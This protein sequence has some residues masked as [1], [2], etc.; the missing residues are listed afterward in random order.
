MPQRKAFTLVELLVVIAILALLLS[1]LV[2]TVTQVTARARQNTC[3]HN[4]KQWGNALLGYR[5]D[6]MSFPMAWQAGGSPSAIWLE[7]N[8]DPSRTQRDYWRPIREYGEITNLMM[9]SYL[10]GMDRENDKMTGP[11]V[12]PAVASQFAY[13]TLAVFNGRSAHMHYG[14]YFGAGGAWDA[15]REQR[16]WDLKVT[17]RPEDFVDI[18]PVEGRIMM[19]DMILGRRGRWL[20]NHGTSGPQAV[21][22]DNS[23]QAQ[24]HEDPR[25][26]SGINLLYGDGSTRWQPGSEMPLDRMRNDPDEARHISGNNKPESEYS[27]HYY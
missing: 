16:R 4:L 7:D 20:F 5:A 24:W 25:D 23:H 27:A 11:W 3:M 14:F 22:N 12:C 15:E 13:G 17:T 21:Y 1:I 18:L 8:F 9:G 2:P 6:N 19:A 10:P 26:I